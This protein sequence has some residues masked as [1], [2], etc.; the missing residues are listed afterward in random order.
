[1]TLQEAAAK[2]RTR[3]DT[4]KTVIGNKGLHWEDGQYHYYEGKIDAYSEAE[5]LINQI[6]LHTPQPWPPPEDNEELAL[7]LAFDSLLKEWRSVECFPSDDWESINDEEGPFSHW[8]PMPEKPRVE[9][10]EKR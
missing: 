6:T 2:V 1:M 5:E 3:I 10:D 4:V 8:L 9:G 7:I